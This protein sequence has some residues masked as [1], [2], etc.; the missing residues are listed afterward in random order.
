MVVWSRCY[1]RQACLREVGWEVVRQGV[2]AH[3]ALTSAAAA[4]SADDGL[5]KAPDAPL[6][7]IV[8]LLDLLLAVAVGVAA[9]RMLG[10]AVVLILSSRAL[11]SHSQSQELTADFPSAPAVGVGGEAQLDAPLQSSAPRRGARRWSAPARRG[12]PATGTPSRQW[13]RFPL[14]LPFWQP[15][16]HSAADLS[17][18]AASD[19]VGDVEMTSL[20]VAENSDRFQESEA[21]S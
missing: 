18:S 19:S 8:G 1:R 9:G 2:L 17:V 15:R 10:V 7:G 16:R 14:H 12:S 11:G 21:D 4:A 3:A 6:N 13:S 5:G 20:R